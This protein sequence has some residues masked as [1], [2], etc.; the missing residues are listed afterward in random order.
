VDTTYAREVTGEGEHTLECHD[1]MLKGLIIRNYVPYHCAIRYV[2]LHPEPEDD[3]GK[4]LA[5]YTR[6]SCRHRQTT[7]GFLYLAH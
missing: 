4:L 3:H 1:E 6:P 5:C 2:A 7:S